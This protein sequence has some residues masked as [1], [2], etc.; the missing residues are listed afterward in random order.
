MWVSSTQ[1]KSHEI[2]RDR[3][4]QT[5]ADHSQQGRVEGHPDRLTAFIFF[6]V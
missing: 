3:M 6:R 5:G 1:T 4:V 2:T